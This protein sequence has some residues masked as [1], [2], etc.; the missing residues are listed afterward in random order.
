MSLRLIEDCLVSSIDIVALK[1]ADSDLI[2]PIE[3][4][5]KKFPHIG[6]RAYFPPSNFNNDIRDNLIQHRTKPVLMKKI[7][8]ILVSDNDGYC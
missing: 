2:P 1:S 5:Q 8:K 4:I 7:T 6:I 3:M